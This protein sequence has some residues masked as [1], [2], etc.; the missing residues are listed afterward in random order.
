MQAIINQKV[1]NML[2]LRN[3]EATAHIPQH[4]L[5]AMTILLSHHTGDPKRAAATQWIAPLPQR[6]C[7]RLRLR[8]AHK[9]ASSSVIQTLVVDQHARKTARGRALREM[10]GW[11]VGC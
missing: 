4:P 11:R 6:A 9:L 7:G 1:I 2:R 5:Q 10:G 3:P 8:F